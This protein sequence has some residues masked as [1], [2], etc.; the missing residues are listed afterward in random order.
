MNPLA[1]TSI[2]FRTVL[3]AVGTDVDGT[4]A[5]GRCSVLTAEGEW[6]DSRRYLAGCPKEASSRK[7]KFTRLAHDPKIFTCGIYS[8]AITSRYRYCAPSTPSQG[9][10]SYSSAK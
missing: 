9:P 8:A 5:A 3:G 4:A 6:R 2:A 7:I 1:V 10:S